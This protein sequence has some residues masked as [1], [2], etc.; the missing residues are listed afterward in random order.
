M[1]NFTAAVVLFGIAAAPAAAGG[2]DYEI[3]SGVIHEVEIGATRIVF[4]VS[5]PCAT[6]IQDPSRD[7]R[8][9]RIETSLKRCIITITKEAFEKSWKHTLVTWADGQRSAKDLA[10]KTAF[11]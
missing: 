9:N 6:Y 8:A 1:G 4:T 11:M 10:G 5:G 7:D 3:K 2:I